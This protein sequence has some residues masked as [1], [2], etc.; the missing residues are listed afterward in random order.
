MNQHFTLVVHGGALNKD[1]KDIPDEKEKAYRQGIEAAL[2]AGWNILK[3]GGGALDAVEAAVRQ[4]EDNPLFNAGK[5]AALSREGIVECDAAIMDGK[6]MKAGAVT[7]VR[8][9]KNPVMLARKVMEKSKHVFLCSEGA[10]DFAGEQQLELRDQQYFITEERQEELKEAQQQQEEKSRHDTIGAVALDQHGNLAAA[11]STGG[12]TNKMK[13]RVSDSPC[14]GC[15]TFAINDVVAVSCTGEGEAMLQSVTA[16]EVYAL[17]KYKQ[18]D[19][20]QACEEAIQVYAEKLEGDRNLIA[21]DPAG[22]IGIAFQT[23]LM[24][25]GY[26][27]KDEEPVIKVWQGE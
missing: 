25:R 4:L 20:Q 27:R 6:T 14:I 3:E 15:G 13:G 19:V 26:R 24:F 10:E 11:T 1:K 23:K 16:H 9:V 8:N 5:G 22:N 12:L 2:E 7:C 17:M 21:V 18:L